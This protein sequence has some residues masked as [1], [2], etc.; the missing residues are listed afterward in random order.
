[1]HQ[2]MVPS[3]GCASLY[4]W[5][6]LFTCVWQLPVG[7]V[8]CIQFTILFSITWSSTHACRCIS[9]C[10]IH[11]E[12]EV[13][14]PNFPL[15]M[16]SFGNK[17]AKE[18]K[19]VYNGEGQPSPSST[20]L[21]LNAKHYNEALFASVWRRKHLLSFFTV[22]T[23]WG[24]CCGGASLKMGFIIPNACPCGQMI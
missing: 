14:I 20:R 2:C 3:R 5:A 18:A 1:M 17:V 6:P 24:L 19:E 15:S 21:Q 22:I 4:V 23:F 8:N 16:H 11:S 12:R 13:R 10:A 7:T 9:G